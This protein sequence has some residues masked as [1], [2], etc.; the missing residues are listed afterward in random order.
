MCS[1]IATSL[2]V[3]GTA[4]QNWELGIT[5]VQCLSALVQAAMFVKTLHSAC[6]HVADLMPIIKCNCLVDRI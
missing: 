3:S 1:P 6:C 2:N 5:A 4:L